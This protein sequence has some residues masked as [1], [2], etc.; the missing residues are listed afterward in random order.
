MVTRLIAV[1]VAATIAVPCAG[2]SYPGK[3]VRII[4]PFAPGGPS[5]LLARTFGQ[6]LSAAWGQPV[7]IDNRGGANGVLGTEATAKSAP[8]GYTLSVGSNGTHGI[9]ASLYPKLPYDTVKDFA[10]ITRLAQVP[11]VIVSHPSLPASTV[12]ELIQLA[13]TRP[14]QVSC[15]S[16]GS[17]S[18]LAA[19]LFKSMA[20]IK[21]LVVPYKGAAL[22]VADVIG[23]Q[24]SMTFAGLAAAMPQVHSGR[25]RALAVTGTGRSV[26]APD[27]PTVQEAG[28][29]GFEVTTWYG[30]F[31]PAGTP[32]AVVERINRDVI[33]AGKLAD[34]RERLV[35][36]AFEP[37]AD[38][39]AEFDQLIRKEIAKWA[40][41][42]KSSGAGTE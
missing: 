25:L 22:A 40:R 42:V 33:T 37:L 1:L 4:V 18:Q 32:P 39:P 12:R 28:V 34:V 26:V 38:T 36:Q 14:S 30:L 41:V 24:I 8:D 2:Q 3:A 23:G 29:P 20:G 31:A 16:G 9:N 13:R 7:V 11:F 19:E 21:L 10:P 6:K 17:P 15:S 35:T 27:V 5:D